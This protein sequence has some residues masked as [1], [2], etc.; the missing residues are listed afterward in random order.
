MRGENESRFLEGS[1]SFELDRRC[2]YHP[3]LLLWNR[4]MSDKDTAE[5]SHTFLIH[6]EEHAKALLHH[7]FIRPRCS[8]LNPMKKRKRASGESDRALYSRIDNP[9]VTALLQKLAFSRLV[10]KRWPSPA[11]SPQ[12]AMPYSDWSDRRPYRLR[13]S[14]LS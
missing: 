4:L 6:D 8:R 13:Q 3:V 10:T 7:P 2:L 9:T 1:V 14:L 12:S 5:T 11:A